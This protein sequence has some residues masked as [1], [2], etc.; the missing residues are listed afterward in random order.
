[1]S[2]K[3]RS[4]C[5]KNRRRRRKRRRRRSPPET[6]ITI[7]GHEELNICFVQNVDDFIVVVV[8]VKDEDV[9]FLINRNRKRDMRLEPDVNVV[10]KTIT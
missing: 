10:N 9:Q 3:L 5:S 1:L 8:V 4:L 7:L 6:T 2:L